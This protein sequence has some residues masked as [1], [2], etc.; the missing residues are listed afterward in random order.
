MGDLQAHIWT[1]A[2]L[3]AITVGA[4]IIFMIAAYAPWII[5]LVLGSG[6]FVFIYLAIYAMFLRQ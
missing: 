1:V 5:L 4:Y 2:V 3:M 6:I